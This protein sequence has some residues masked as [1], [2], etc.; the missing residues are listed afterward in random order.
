MNI[1]NICWHYDPNLVCNESTLTHHLL[2]NCAI[3]VQPVNKITN[4][5][6]DFIKKQSVNKIIKHPNQGKPV[7]KI[8]KTIKGCKWSNQG[9]FIKNNEIVCSYSDSVVNTLF[10]YVKCYKCSDQIEITIDDMIVCARCNYLMKIDQYNIMCS[11]L[12]YEVLRIRC[13]ICYKC[14]ASTYMILY[15]G[16][17]IIH[18]ASCNYG[19]T[20]NDYVQILLS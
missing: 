10:R 2:R 1:T 20:F 13:S 5:S 8:V 7:D 19:Y 15:E 3:K 4:C 16:A 9:E 14:K 6:G 18:C 17:E 11:H 12:A